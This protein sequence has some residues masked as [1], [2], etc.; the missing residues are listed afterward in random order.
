[1]LGLG[2]DTDGHRRISQGEN[3]TLIGGTEDTHEVMIEKSI[4]INEKLADR[5]KALEEVS[6]EEF[7]DIAQ[8]V[9]LKRYKSG[10]DDR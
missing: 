10:D 2:L 9:G 6:Q 7:S 1:M 3:F 8:S 5:G 4:K